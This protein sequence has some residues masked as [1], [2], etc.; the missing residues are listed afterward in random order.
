MMRYQRE[1]YIPDSATAVDCGDS[2][3]AV[4]A[5]QT[6][7]VLYGVAFHGK[8]SK[9]D[10]HHRFKSADQMAN[11]V[12]ESIAG[13]RSHFEYKA[14]RTAARAKPHTLKPGD[15]LYSSW[16]Y[17]Q[18][19]VDFYK[20]LSV[21]RRTATI[22]KVGLETVESNGPSDRV[23]A[24]PDHEIG[25]PMKNKRVDTGWDREMITIDSVSRAYLWD[26][27]PRHQT[28]AGYGH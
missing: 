4:Y 13:R 1:S 5:Y 22:I 16:G 17:D 28:G 19:N 23:V 21:T 9:P 7:G 18:T 3:M 26:G 2:D 27:T 8:A 11:K 20:V 12:A 6:A 10:W 14:K 25:K 24:V 15:I